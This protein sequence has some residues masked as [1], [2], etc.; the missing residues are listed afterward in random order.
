MLRQWFIPS[1]QV[2]GIRW[3]VPKSQN[4]S[5][6]LPWIIIFPVVFERKHAQTGSW[7]TQ[8]E[9]ELIPSGPK[10]FPDEDNISKF[11]LTFP[12]SN[13]NV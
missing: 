3:E 10:Y 2:P 13:V 4:G 6:I 11:S 8:Q 9:N 5:K 7:L 12:P 1:W